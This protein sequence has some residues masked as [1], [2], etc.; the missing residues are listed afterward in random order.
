MCSTHKINVVIIQKIFVSATVSASCKVWLRET[1][2]SFLKVLFKI[3][4]FCVMTFFSLQKRNIFAHSSARHHVQRYLTNPFFKQTMA[5]SVP[6]INVNLM[7][8]LDPIL[9]LHC[10]I[11]FQRVWL[12]SSVIQQSKQEHTNHLNILK[13]HYSAIQ[14]LYQSDISCFM[15]SYCILPLHNSRGILP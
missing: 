5:S 13:T 2:S 4:C 10:S 3:I 6:F 7:S 1:A 11:P 9:K 14:I 15:C 8:F 12:S